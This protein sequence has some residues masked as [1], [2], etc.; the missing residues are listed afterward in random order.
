MI[1][2][3]YNNILK[4]LIGIQ[5]QV[6]I[7]NNTK[8]INYE[9]NMNQTIKNASEMR[10]EMNISDLNKQ[11]KDMKLSTTN[12]LNPHKRSKKIKKMNK[13]NENTNNEWVLL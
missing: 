7:Y 13:I 4:A 12:E 11:I 2:V 9:L 8:V 10:T 3:L 5:K 1:I 6:K